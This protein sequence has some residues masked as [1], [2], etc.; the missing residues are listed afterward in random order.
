[1]CA[2]GGGSMWEQQKACQEGTEIIVA[3]PVSTIIAG[4]IYK[5]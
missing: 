2:Y 5:W 1:V 4:S 3:T